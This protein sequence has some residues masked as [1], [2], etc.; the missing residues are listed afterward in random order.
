M[1]ASRIEAIL[2]A[3]HT[4][5]KATGASVLRNEVVPTA[6]SSSGTIIL[7]DGTPGEPWVTMSPLAY[8]YDHMAQIE[9]YVQKKT[10]RDALFDGLK[11][12]IG[13]IV[14]ADRTLGGLCSWIEA[15]APETS[16]LAM[17]GA[18]NIKAAL[19][20]VQVTYVTTD[21]LA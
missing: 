17:D 14:G 10:G 5:L 20:L 16:D 12:S 1:A 4:A 9:V 3:L 7:R 21:P 13:Q 15:A 18:A 2:A 19:I 11:Q 8:E 6:V